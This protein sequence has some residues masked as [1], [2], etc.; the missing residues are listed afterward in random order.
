MLMIEVF[1]AT[2][3]NLL[4]ADQNPEF[5]DRFHPDGPQFVR[6][7]SAQ[8]GKVDGGAFEDN[9]VVRSV[10]IAEEILASG[11]G[12]EDVLGSHQVFRA[13]RDRMRDG[14][15]DTI[16]LIHGFASGFRCS[17]ER[18][19]ELKEKYTV[20]G[21]EPNVFVFSWPSDAKVEY[22]AYFSDRDDAKASAMAMARSFLKFRDWLIRE[23][24]KNFCQQNIHLVAHSM[25]V[26]ATRHAVQAI[27]AELG[28]NVPRLFDHV[29]LMAGDED[30]DAF[31]HDHKFR[32]LPDMAKQVHVYFSAN[33]GALTTSDVTKSNV[34]RLG[35]SGPRI[36]DNIS[37]KITLVDC[38]QVD[39]TLIPHG[40]H[41]YYRLRPEVIED[42]CQVLAGTP[43]NLISNRDFIHDDRSFRIKGPPGLGP[44]APGLLPGGK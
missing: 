44:I 2:N 4:G 28:N 29:F 11:T 20:A 16:V 12:G 31:E 14:T 33:D 30:N 26:Y 34:D 37:R 38:R 22:S 13:L 10:T 17:L 8:V 32:L 9:Y 18:A 3:R 24:R 21:R 36:N 27:R 43:A 42:V 7:G 15:T 25:G 41:Q 35:S 5:G 40:R 39:L 1:F 6:F 19:A 23:G